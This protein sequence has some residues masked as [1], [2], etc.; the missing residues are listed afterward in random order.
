MLCFMIMFHFYI[1]KHCIYVS[2]YDIE[3]I[4]ML[5]IFLSC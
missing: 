4:S 3:T 2:F 5:E 1:M